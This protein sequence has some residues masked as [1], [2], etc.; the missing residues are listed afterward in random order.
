MVQAQLASMSFNAS[1]C[2]ETLFT[3]CML[4]QWLGCKQVFLYSKE[5][6]KCSPVGS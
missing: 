1:F 5:E 2:Q 3:F 4:Q 6:C